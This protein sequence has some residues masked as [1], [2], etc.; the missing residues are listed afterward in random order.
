MSSKIEISEPEIFRINI[1][2]NFKKILINNY[3]ICKNLELA[4]YNYSIQEAK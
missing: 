2:N 1:T 3:K 4:I